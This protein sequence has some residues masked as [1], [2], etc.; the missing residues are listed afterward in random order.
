MQFN[1]IKYVFGIVFL[2]FI[3]CG[4]STKKS[5]I[6]FSDLK[7]DTTIK[8]AKR[9]SIARNKDL[10]VVYLFGNR[11]N[12]DTTA[13][14]V[15]YKD[16]S[17]ITNVSKNATLVRSPCK[18]IA[19]LSSIYASM[20]FELGLLNSIAAI[21][22]A[23]YI[24]NKEIISK[25]NN[26]Q[27]LE[28][29]KGI[30]ID[31]EQTIKLNPNIIFTFGMGDPK[32]DI[33]PKLHLTKIPVAI[34]LDHTEETPLARAEWIKF[35]AAF[36][37]KKELADSIFKTVEKNYNELKLI[38]S[39]A[40]NKPS[41]FNE[42]KYSDSWYMPGGKSYVAQLLNDAGTNYLWKEDPNSG[43]IPL[44]FEQV[45]AKAKDADFWINQSML[46]T[47]K[48]ILSFDPRYAEFNAF[49]KGNVYNNTKTTNSKGYTTYWETG[50]IYP[51]RVLSDLIQIFHPELK[52]QIK[53]DLYYYEQLK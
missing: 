39:K 17:S 16:S 25:C 27:I 7:K 45:Y 53:N 52:Q 50:M 20:L 23:D 30:N 32:K 26:K 6:A 44:S 15:I 18:N 48:E 49:K 13:T 8:Y 14:Y 9:F 3:S 47:K 24:N 36:V 33:D 29:A 12:F 1:F 46:K 21:D 40:K 34:S 2:I 28:L 37:D 35:F 5:A 38:T 22:N 31:V 42:I 51:D 43:S 10:T 19:A 11:S 4:T 41:V